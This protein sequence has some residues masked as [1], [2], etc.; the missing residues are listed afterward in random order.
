MSCILHLV[1]SNG[2]VAEQLGEALAVSG[3]PVRLTSLRHALPDVVV[4]WV[5][6]QVD[7]IFL[8]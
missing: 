5:A 1:L 4:S 3:D 6:L 7:N 8:T 2:K